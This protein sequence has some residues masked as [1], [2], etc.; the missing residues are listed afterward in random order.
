MTAHAHCPLLQPAR[1]IRR[2]LAESEGDVPRALLAPLMRALREVEAGQ[3]AE[4]LPAQPVRRYTEAE[5]AE[6]VGC[7]AWTLAERRRSGVL[8]EGVHYSRLVGKIRYT[9]AH[10]SRIL[11]GQRT[12]EGETWQ[13]SRRRP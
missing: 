1:D 9:D 13:A 7:S 3:G 2:H 6:M 11:E 5:A 4:P 12:R 10:L 8:K